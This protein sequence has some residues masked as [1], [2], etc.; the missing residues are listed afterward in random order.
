MLNWIILIAL[1]FL[2]W[3]CV[4]QL[5]VVWNSDSDSSGAV[6]CFHLPLWYCI[7]TGLKQ[8]YRLCL[9][10]LESVR[11]TIDGQWS[12]A[13]Y[14]IPE[15]CRVSCWR[16]CAF[17]VQQL[18][19]EPFFTD[20]HFLPLSYVLALGKA[21]TD[22]TIQSGRFF[23]RSFYCSKAKICDLCCEVNWWYIRQ[24]EIS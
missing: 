10:R 2:W 1:F 6:L 22:C 4:Q 24:Y 5:G 14:A 13:L 20:N 7:W 8:R 15:Y 9:I 11:A 3:I 21:L 19:H 16:W 23:S 12:A 17:C 18:S